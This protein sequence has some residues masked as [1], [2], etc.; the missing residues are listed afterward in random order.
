MKLDQ[1]HKWLAVDQLSSCQA[2]V[3]RALQYEMMSWAV[4]VARNRLLIRSNFWVDREIYV[5]INYPF[6]VAADGIPSSTSDPDHRL[7][8]Y[9]KG[10][11][12]QT[13]G[14]GPHKD[15]WYGHS[16]NAIN[17]WFAVCGTNEQSTMTIYPEHAY[18]A[19]S[20]NA[21]TM[22][23]SYSEHLGK[24]VALKLERGENFIFD[25]ELLHATRLNTSD[26]TRVV[27]TLRVAPSKPLFSDQIKHDIYDNWIQADDIDKGVLEPIKVGHLTTIDDYPET[28]SLQKK[29]IHEVHSRNDLTTENLNRNDFPISDN[30]VFEIS[31][32]DIDCLGVWHR[33]VLYKFGKNCPHIGAP[34]IGGSFDIKK[35]SIKC[36]A[37]GVEFCLKSGSS[38]SKKL[39]LRVFN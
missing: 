18:K 37:H 35:L 36:P 6:D 34:L 5:R 9:N 23:A 33:G 24:N 19:T 7:T 29:Y 1:L 27:L 28:S 2:Y 3:T 22:Y 31:G 25:P 12:R 8:K 10:R 32:R 21:D 15:S 26:Q 38:G 39:R 11:P 17:F 14:H 4:S 30:V 20:F 13:W 16:H